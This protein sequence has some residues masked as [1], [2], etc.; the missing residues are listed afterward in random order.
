MPKLISECP[1]CHKTNVKEVKAFNI[2]KSKFITLDCSHTYRETLSI[3]DDTKVLRLKDGK[4]P[5]PFQMEG[6][7]FAERSGFNCLIADEPGLGKT[8]QALGILHLHLD[9]LKPVLL[10]A[11]AGLTLQWQK[12]FITCLDKFAQVVNSKSDLL[13][14][15]SIYITSFDTAGKIDWTK[16]NPKTI[17][18][19]ECQ[20]IKNHD[21]Q[22]TNAIRAI[23]NRTEVKTPTKISQAERSLKIKRAEM[24]AKN[25]M[26]YH[27]I[28]ERFNFHIFAHMGNKLGLC[29]CKVKGEGII[30]G[31]IF[32]SKDHV[33]KDSENEI[34]ETILHE[35]A[36]AITPGAGHR[37]I[38]V[39]TAKSIHSTGEPIVNCE[40]SI[41]EQAKITEPTV[42]Y[43]LFLSGTPIKNNAIEYWPAL[44]LL[45]P[46]L[47][48]NRKSFVQNEVGY[49]INSKGVNKPGGIRYPE[50]FKKKTADFIIRR[51]KKEVLPEL[52][53][54]TRDFRYHEMNHDE[55]Q[56]YALGIKK[57]SEFLKN[58]NRKAF[59]FN[60]EL[61]GHIMILRHVTGLAKIAPVLEYIDDWYDEDEVKK[62]AIFHH[63]ID[64][65]NILEKH[66]VDREIGIIRIKSSMDVTERQLLLD[67]F[68][69]D[70][71]KRI[72]IAPTLA[73]GEGYDLDYVDTG[74]LLEREWNP[75]NEEQVEGRFIRATPDS[76]KKA[77]AGLLKATIVMPVAVATIDEYFAELVE[78]KRQ[79]VKETLDG[80]AEYQWDESEI[81]LEL[82]QIAVDRWKN[83]A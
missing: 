67:K 65:G 68:K 16:T 47:F 70:S 17:I 58:S 34:L 22:R 28:S 32:L 45:R 75:A 76:I 40:G 13:P 19:D 29:I 57:L 5:Y 33:E 31:D 80:K 4:I 51:T 30:T 10:I 46:A 6:I 81:M 2:G 35:V 42:K 14:G 55:S 52:P 62:I 72:M 23:V 11:K 79:Y 37:P 15:L 61:Q 83:V 69:N 12:Y 1:V 48:P 60:S 20:M 3:T 64:V 71:S 38:W 39:D 25:L 53:E 21:A 9:K 66:L 43:K 77:Q 74:I 56:A 59:Q 49:Y 73:M 8:I 63:H 26:D 41:Q 36:H 27:G 44:N 54:I 18:L 24:F 7:H 78:R 82:A 50:D